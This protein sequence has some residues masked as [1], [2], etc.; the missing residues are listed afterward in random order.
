M[1]LWHV[2]NCCD[3][4]GNSDIINSFLKSRQNVN[5]LIIFNRNKYVRLR[6]RP[7]IHT[8]RSCVHTP[9]DFGSHANTEALP[10]LNFTS[11]WVADSADFVL[12][13]SKVPQNVYIASLHR[14]PMNLRAKF[15]AVRFSLVREI[16]NRTNTQKT[17]KRTKSMGSN[18]YI[19]NVNG[20]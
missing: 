11:R 14:T 10:T 13:G 19:I 8:C 15:D 4:H 6:W 18:I 12:L 9:R 20:H 1:G 2:I 3:V 7:Y 17:Y 16:R 5:H